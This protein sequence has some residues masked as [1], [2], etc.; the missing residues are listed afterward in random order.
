MT[1]TNSKNI[2]QVT[3][4]F[5][6]ELQLEGSFDPNKLFEIVTSA[7]QTD[8]RYNDFRFSKEQLEEMA[9]NFNNDLL[10]REIAVDLNHDE[11]GI[12]L[13]WI[14][15]DSMVVKESSRL[16]GEYSL[17]A[18]LYRFTPKGEELLST[19]AVRYFSI[20]LKH[21][22]DRFIN[23]M[24]RKIN[25]VIVGLA[26]TN[27]PVV[28]DMAPTFSEDKFYNPN[29]MSKKE[30]SEEEAKAA[31]AEAQEEKDPKA[32][33]EEGEQPES[34][35]AEAEEAEAEESA[36]A[37]EAEAAEL[38][39]K[40]VSKIES[41]KSYSE[42]EVRA[43]LA[44]SV[45]TAVAEPMKKLNE[46]LVEAR[47]SKLSAN[48][49]SL[50]LSEDKTVGLKAGSKDRVLSFVKKLS[51]SLA[52]EYFS[53]HENAFTKVDL[54]ERG[55]SKKGKEYADKE[56]AQKNFDKKVEAA[57]KKEKM[58]AAA[59]FKKVAEENPELA[60]KLNI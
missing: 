58:T 44:E 32:N 22:M 41:K 26:L 25:N 55:Y 3:Q 24:K 56:A 50:C 15:P 1:N 21:K 59:A 8:P 46:M 45:K 34:E 28:K 14:K 4:F 38:A 23:N 12:A 48:V 27:R 51:D 18:Q 16:K 11:E 37:E 57:M 7:K 2:D 36:E 43:L 54:S 20:E 42:A 52:E 47:T 17:Y 29:N 49:D 31:E 40:I 60:K 19:G 6:S 9:Y 33:T 35:N 53:I 30:L 39:E 5:C 10:G 13:A